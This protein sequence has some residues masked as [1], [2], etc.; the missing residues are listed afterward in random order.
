MLLKIVAFTHFIYG[1]HHIMFV[2]FQLIFQDAG[3]RPDAKTLL[4]HPWI[5]NSRRALQNTLRHS[6]TLR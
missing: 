4:S 3:L 5:Q 2:P 6:G 1:Y